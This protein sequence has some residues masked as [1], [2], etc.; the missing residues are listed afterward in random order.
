MI[1]VTFIT[2]ITMLLL[3]S[4]VFAGLDPSFSEQAVVDTVPFYPGGTYND[5]IPKPNDYLRNPV[6]DYPSRYHEIVPYLEALAAASDR[7][8]LESYGSTHEGRML[9]N[10]FVSSKEN[11]SNLQQ[12]HE[13]MNRLADPG[14][15]SDEAELNRLVADLPAVAWLG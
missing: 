4:G 10:L 11:I 5:A 13:S 15:I 2:L 1:R 6:G 12:L 9:Y 3:A 14:Q 7:V 8:V